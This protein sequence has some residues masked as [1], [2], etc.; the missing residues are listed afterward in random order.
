MKILWTRLKKLPKWKKSENGHQ[1][2]TN[3]DFFLP[4]CIVVLFPKPLMLLENSMCKIM[5]NLCSMHI[6]AKKKNTTPSKNN[7]FSMFLFFRSRIK[8]KNIPKFLK[9]RKKFSFT[10]KLLSSLLKKMTL[11]HS[12]KKNNKTSQLQ[13]F[14]FI[15]KWTKL[16]P[17]TVLSVP[18]FYS[19]IGKQKFSSPS[20]N[21]IRN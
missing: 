21:W 18:R 5:C 3:P 14:V 16:V 8:K 11:P 13:K 10:R 7:F 6:K 15:P 19:W 4:F 2:K 12:C 17:K 20:L 1:I 9:Q